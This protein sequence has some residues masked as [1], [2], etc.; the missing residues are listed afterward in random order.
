M[1]RP[2][3]GTSQVPLV[4]LSLQASAPVYVCLIGDNGRKL[5]PGT[6][7]QPGSRTATYHAKHFLI[8]LGN[9][10]V[11]M[12]VDGK[13]RTVPASAEAIGYSI[14]RANGRRLLRTGQLPSCK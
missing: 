11:T 4:A 9:N 5:I 13:E 8:T 14:T 6:E 10:S 3:T 2:S 12:F 7:L 1:R